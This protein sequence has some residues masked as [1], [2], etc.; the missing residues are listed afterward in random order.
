[1][2]DAPGVVLQD[3]PENQ[4]Y[5]MPAGCV[6]LNDVFVGRI[7]KDLDQD[8]GF[9]M[10]VVSDNLLKGAA[11]NS[12]QIAESLIRLGLVKISE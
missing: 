4:L 10:W 9:H 7:R 5:P 3:D 8:N 11:W 12:V 6:G 2:K 1:L